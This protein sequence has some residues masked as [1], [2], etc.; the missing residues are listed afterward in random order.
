LITLN[1]KGE[2]AAL[3]THH[4]IGKEIRSA[5]ERIGGTMPE[6]LPAE[7]SVKKLA[8]EHK[9]KKLIPPLS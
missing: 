8:V 2:Q 4:R 1:I 9:Q 3:D 5:I 6:D 7:E